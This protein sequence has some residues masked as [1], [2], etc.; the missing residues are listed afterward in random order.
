VSEGR[1]TDAELAEWAEDTPF[2][3]WHE[4]TMAREI[5]EL[6]AERERWKAQLEA[7]WLAKSQPDQKVDDLLRRATWW[8]LALN[9]VGIASAIW[10]ST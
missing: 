1:F 8:L 5:I 2:T 7:Q 6:R 10:M 3:A 9:V 4:R